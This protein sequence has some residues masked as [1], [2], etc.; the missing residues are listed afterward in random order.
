MAAFKNTLM[1]AALLAMVAGLSACDDGEDG[2]NGMDGTDGSDGSNG[3][4]SLVAHTQLAEGNANCPAGGVQ[5]DSGLDSSADG[6]LDAD[7][8]TDTSYVCS[9]VSAQSFQRVATL[10]VCLQDEAN[11]DSDTTTA[12]EIVAAS[13]DGLTLIYSDSPA[14]RIGFV[15]IT[16]PASPQALGTLAMAGEPT[17]VAVR[18]GYALVAVNTS[19]DFINVSGQ[20]AVVDIATQA[21]VATLP[22]SGQ[23]DS[24]AISPDGQY[25]AIVIENER[26]EDLNDGVPPQL[27]AGTLGIVQLDGE[28]A[29]WVVSQ[30]DLTGIAELYAT[31]PE[32]E[33]VDINSDNLAAVTLQENN[34]VVLVDLATASVVGDF[35]AGSVDLTGIDATEESPALV[36]QTESLEGVLREPDGIA[37]LGNGLL[38]T[39]DEGDLDGGSRGFTVF[40][41]QGEVVF[42]AGNALDRIAARLGHYPD[43][44]SEN[45]GNEPEN[46]EYGVYG[47]HKFL[48]VASERSSL[49]FVYDVT[50]PANPAYLQTLPAGVGPE[51]VLAIPSRNLLIAANEEDSRGDIYRS[52]LSIYRYQD[53]LPT[54]PTIRSADRADGSPIPWAALSGLAADPASATTLYGV[55]DSYFQQNRIFTLDLGT[56]PATLTAELRIADTSDVFAA[57]PVV[58][59]ADPSVP[60]DDASRVSVFD[61]ADLD[62]LINDDKSVNIDPEGIAVASDGG[63]WIASEGAGTIGDA[64]RP[65]NSLNFIF[66]LDAAGVI[67]QVVTLP[68]EVNA[69]QQRFGYE[70][71]AEYDGS[72][73]VAFQRAWAGETNPRLGIYDVEAGTWSFLFYPLE[74]VAS[75]NG[76]WVGLSDLTALGNGEFLVVERDN[77]GGPDA[78]IKR[79]YRFDVSGLADGATVTK[80]LVRDLMDDLQAPGGVVP[81]KI[82]GLAVAV[83]GDVIIVNDNDGVEDNSGET[84]LLNLGAILTVAEE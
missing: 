54:Y 17:S 46:V 83:D 70:G 20:L 2:S 16:D 73:Y 31:D 80:T 50:D 43:S 76:G 12:A 45:K 48:F 72:A 10:P 68:D 52:S 51:G 59:L 65:I 38:A 34:H 23:P 25:A 32:P 14:E 64:A 81:E 56:L 22:L 57:V 40:N 37:W 78:A 26:D 79:L 58:D 53:G 24:V 6:V 5:I 77:Q 4:N 8:I 74:P 62:A 15:D 61:E 71:I 41:T 66:K 3:L 35:S 33:F 82:E 19:E 69:L 13:V 47:D 9:E 29:S 11:C 42:G 21:L 36:S 67:E 75:Q 63:F 39:A 28:P 27:P 1:R 44:R 60:A 30:V 7:E 18:G 55:D 84:Q 49:V